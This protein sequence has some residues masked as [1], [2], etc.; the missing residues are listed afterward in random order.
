MGGMNGRRLGNEWGDSFFQGTWL[1]R[2]REALSG[3]RR[4]I[5]GRGKIHFQDGR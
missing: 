4:K 1:Q 2:R 5:W 3:G